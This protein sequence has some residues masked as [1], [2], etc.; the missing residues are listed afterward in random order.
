MKRDDS[1]YLKHVRDAIETIELYLRGIDEE[2]FGQK[3]MVQDA[4][5]RQL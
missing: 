4:V 1:V 3:R 5:F 2:S